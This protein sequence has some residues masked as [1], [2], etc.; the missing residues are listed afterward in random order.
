MLH[1]LGANKVGCFDGGGCFVP[2]VLLTMGWENR[3]GTVFCVFGVYKTVILAIWT[4]TAVQ[5]HTAR[6]DGQLCIF[7]VYFHHHTLAA[8]GN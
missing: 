4:H 8:S 5:N 2:Y 6:N 1:F 7:G 3:S